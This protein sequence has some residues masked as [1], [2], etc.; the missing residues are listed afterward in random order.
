MKVSLLRERST[1]E[2]NKMPLIYTD[3]QIEQKVA[4]DG[5]ELYRAQLLFPLVK[6][7]FNQAFWWTEKQTDISDRAEHTAV[8][9]ARVRNSGR[10]A[11]GWPLNSDYNLQLKR[12][13]GCFVWVKLSSWNTLKQFHFKTASTQIKETEKSWNMTNFY[14]WIMEWRLG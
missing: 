9:E 13:G 14:L 10:L 7:W 4:G 3:T 6:H 12:S 2:L 5:P 11:F 8:G 1:G